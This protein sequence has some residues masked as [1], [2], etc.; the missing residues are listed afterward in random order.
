MTSL[1]SN[2]AATPEF[3]PSVQRPPAV[4]DTVSAATP[5]AAALAAST[6]PSEEDLRLVIE[7][8]KSSGGF[9]Y[10]TMNRLTGEL[11]SQFPREDVLRMR[12]AS[13]YVPGALVAAKA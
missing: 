5:S 13:N 4:P 7:P 6:G 11:V 1:V 9:I 8:D 2:L 12:D 10:K 3:P